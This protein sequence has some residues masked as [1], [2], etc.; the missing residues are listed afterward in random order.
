MYTPGFELE[1]NQQSIDVR[2]ELS[3]LTKYTEPQGDA[4]ALQWM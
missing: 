3:L 2:A 1:Q 4:Q